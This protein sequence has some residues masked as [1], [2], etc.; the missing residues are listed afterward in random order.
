MNTNLVINL[1]NIN[2][3]QGIDQVA[4]NTQ[5]DQQKSSPVS[6]QNQPTKIENEN[7]SQTNITNTQ[8][9]EQIIKE[10]QKNLT[11]L[12]THLS[13]SIDTKLDQPI[14]KIV[15]NSTNQVVPPEYMLNSG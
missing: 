1:L 4:A 12:N 13:I 10:L 6:S 8:K 9:I 3:G 14:I 2:Y 5:E 15:D 11:Y 7:Y